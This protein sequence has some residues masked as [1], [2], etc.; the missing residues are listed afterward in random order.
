M[1]IF[2]LKKQTRQKTGLQSYR[3]LSF[4]QK[5]VSSLPAGFCHSWYQPIGGHLTKLITANAEFSHI[6]SGPSSQFAAIAYA[7]T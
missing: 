6:S 2:C 1:F 7:H 3:F 5:L 4:I